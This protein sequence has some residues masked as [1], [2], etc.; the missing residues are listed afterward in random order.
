VSR[1]YRRPYA[2]F[3]SAESAH[4]DKKM[5]ARG[6]RRRLNQWLHILHDPEAA[7]PPHRFECPHNNTYAW[8]RDG[9]QYLAYPYGPGPDDGWA[10]RRWI[11]LHRK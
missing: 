7:L 5:A 9:R 10:Y 1:S 6:L 8:E 3:T 11:K 2:A 4:E